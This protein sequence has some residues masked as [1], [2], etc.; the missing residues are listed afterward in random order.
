VVVALVLATFVGLALGL[1]GG[2]GSMLSV[3]VLSF[4]LDMSPKAAIAGSL[5]VIAVTSSAALLAQ[6]GSRL[7]SVRTGLAFGGVGM[8]GAFAGG[9]LAGFV[10]EAALQ[11]AFG[12]LMLLTSVGMLRVNTAGREVDSSRDGRKKPGCVA[13][14]LALALSVG[15]VTGL[16]GA[17]GG[18]LIVPALVLYRGMPMKRAAATSLL[19]IALQS[20]AGFLGHLGQASLDWSVVLPFTLMAVF[21]GVVGARL[22]E[23]AP[24]QVLQ[25]GFA[26]LVLLV[27]MAVV[28]RTLPQLFMQISWAR[29]ARP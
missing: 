6:R 9:R 5:L 11:T 15:L 23:R 28:A 4:A 2:G 22:A 7:V 20:F 3:A 24:A 12:L 27:A 17:G 19:V 25:R 16:L 18:F 14:V 13:R 1:F 29:G 21:G 8:L 26:G 10:P